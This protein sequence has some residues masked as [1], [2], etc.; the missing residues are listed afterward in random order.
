MAD[1][2]RIKSNTFFQKQNHLKLKKEEKNKSVIFDAAVQRAAGLGL[3][4]SAA[5][6]V[7]YTALYAANGIAPQLVADFASGFYAQ[8]GAA[9]DFETLFAATTEAT[10]NGTMV[11]SDGVLK[12]RPHNLVLN[13][14]TPATQSI[15]VVSGAEYTVECTGVSIALSGA[16]T[17]TVT[18]GNPV[19]ITASTTT[20]TLTVTGSTGT[21]WAYRSD[22][23]GMVDNPATGDSYVPTTTAARYLPRLGHH[24]YTY[25][26]T[27]IK[28]RLAPTIFVDSVSGSDSNSGDLPSQ[29]FETLAAAT[30]AYTTGDVIGLKRGGVWRESLSLGDGAQ[31]TAY[32]NRNVALPKIDCADVAANADFSLTSGQTNTYE[33]SWTHELGEFAKNKIRVW[34]DG[35][36]LKWVASIADCEAEAGTF[37]VDNSALTNPQTVYVHPNGSTNPTSDGKTYEI[38]RRGVAVT[39]GANSDVREIHTTRNGSHNGSLVSGLYSYLEG[40]LATDGIL[41][42]MWLG[43]GGTA[44]YCVAYGAEPNWRNLGGTFFVSYWGVSLDATTRYENCYAVSDVTFFDGMEGFYEHANGDPYTHTGLEFINCYYKGWNT[45]A[46]NGDAENLVINGFFAEYD[47]SHNTDN[48]TFANFKTG[49]S[50][51]INNVTVL[52]GGRVFQTVRDAKI[53]NARIHIRP[54]GTAG[55]IFWGAGADIQNSSFAFDPAAAA[56][57]NM[58]L[59]STAS[60]PAV[61]KNNIVQDFRESVVNSTTGN[62]VESDFNTY[63]TADAAGNYWLFDTTAV[64]FAAWKAATGQDANSTYDFSQASTILRMRATMTG[65]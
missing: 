60:V 11:D 8:D 15:T 5:G 59:W 61:F 65:R 2:P 51:T 3:T 18:A 22:L 27:T 53:T 32:G 1:Q 19:T 40:C 30:A 56:N 64:S 41:H 42:N 17:G 58:F 44:K 50:G 10:S 24:I 43:V 31:I 4:I 21:M 37:F 20:L 9:S 25:D 49:S 13:S 63:W 46:A 36:R 39:V 55:G 6:G 47:S 23:G 16:G 33:L 35:Q 26:T 12:W 45:A 7:S 62:I 54:F 38:A 34:E 29:A 48:S 28:T 57:R 14:A 52:N